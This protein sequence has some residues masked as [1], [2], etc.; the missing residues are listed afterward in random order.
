MQKNPNLTIASLETDQSFPVCEKTASYSGDF[1]RTLTG[2]LNNSYTF[3]FNNPLAFL[4]V[5][6]PFSEGGV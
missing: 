1:W 3:T 6:G 2:F 4:N 5:K